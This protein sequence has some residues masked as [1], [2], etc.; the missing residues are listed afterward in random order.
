MIAFSSPLTIKAGAL[1]YR[2]FAKG[3][4]K[5]CLCKNQDIRDSDFTPKIE[6]FLETGGNVGVPDKVTSEAQ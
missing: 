2:A 6:G 5:N 3:Q 4:P 1:Y